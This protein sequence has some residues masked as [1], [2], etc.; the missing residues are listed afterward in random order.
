M[1]QGLIKPLWSVSFAVSKSILGGNGSIRL[2]ADDAFS[3]RCTNVKIV[4]FGQEAWYKDDKHAMLRIS[5]LYKFHSGKE[6]KD[7][8]TKKEIIES[9]RIT[10]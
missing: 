2:F 10:L 4:S 3:S 5:F 6:M 7:S 1:G 8:H 9:K